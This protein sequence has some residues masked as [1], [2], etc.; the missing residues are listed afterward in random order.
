MR[1]YTDFLG[2]QPPYDALEAADLETLARLVEVDYFVAGT[3]IVAAGSAPL[4]HFYVV[5]SGE[6]EVIDRGRVVDVLGPGETF[7]QISVLSGLPPPLTVR[8]AEDSLGYRFPVGAP[9]L[10]H[11]SRVHR[12]DRRRGSPAPLRA[13]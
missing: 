12:S 9:R 1:E 7:G 6:V 13:T 2:G 8:A 3:I 10:P 4:S 11:R 5:R